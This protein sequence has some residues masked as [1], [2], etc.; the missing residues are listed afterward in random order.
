MGIL[1]GFLG[2][3]FSKSEGGLRAFKFSLGIHKDKLR[4]FCDIEHQ[5]KSWK[6]FSDVMN[7]FSRKCRD[8]PQ[9]YVKGIQLDKKQRVLL[10]LK[11]KSKLSKACNRWIY[12]Q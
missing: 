10:H 3:G 9:M 2:G 6:A 8:K 4:L 5:S 12:F 1:T 7:W 11:A